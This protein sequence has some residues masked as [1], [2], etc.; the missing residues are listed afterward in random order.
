MQHSM[1]W[2][3]LG[4]ISVAMHGYCIFSKIQPMNN[5]EMSENFQVSTNTSCAKMVQK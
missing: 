2:L 4:N 1:A 5:A 3:T